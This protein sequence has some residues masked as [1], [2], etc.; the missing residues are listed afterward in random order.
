MILHSEGSVFHSGGGVVIQ[1]VEVRFVTG[2]SQ[3]STW[4][5]AACFTERI[6]GVIPATNYSHHW[7]LLVLQLHVYGRK[8]FKAIGLRKIWYLMLL[9]WQRDNP[10]TQYLD[11]GR[12]DLQYSFLDKGALK[13]TAESDN[14]TEAIRWQAEKTSEAATQCGRGGH[15]Q[16]V[17]SGWATSTSCLENWHLNFEVKIHIFKRHLTTISTL[18]TLN[19]IYIIL[20]NLRFEKSAGSQ[21]SSLGLVMAYSHSLWWTRTNLTKFN[22]YSWGFL[23][24]SPYTGLSY[25]TGSHGKSML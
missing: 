5:E 14:G 12:G 25:G 7:F 9:K 17:R 10:Q 6:T 15:Q 23:V 13:M 18:F 19:M 20:I 22:Y 3:Q 24:K 21:R 8:I 16:D 4:S 1:T 11:T 2:S